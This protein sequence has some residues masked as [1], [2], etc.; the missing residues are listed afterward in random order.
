MPKLE[1][2]LI[3]SGKDPEGIIKKITNYIV[4][5]AQDDYKKNKKKH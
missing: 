4:K 5:R 1:D 2:E 3:N